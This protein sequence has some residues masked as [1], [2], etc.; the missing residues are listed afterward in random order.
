VGALVKSVIHE[1]RNHLAVAI[2]NIEAF[3]DGVL[4]PTPQRLGAVLRALGEV[5][6]LLHTLPRGDTES[7]AA[8]RTE[9]SA[10]AAS[11]AMNPETSP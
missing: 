2:A 6:A 10:V 3:Q 9:R 5:E 4:E 11:D 8:A 7:P 1:I